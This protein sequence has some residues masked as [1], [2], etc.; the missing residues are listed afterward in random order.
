MKQ[1]TLDI[2]NLDD[3]PMT[4]FDYEQNNRNDKFK[5]LIQLILEYD[6]VVFASPVYW[7]AMSAQMKVFFDRF[8]DLLT[9]SKELG[10]LLRGKSCSVIAT[11]TDVELPNCFFRPFEL[12]AKYL[13]MSFEGYGYLSVK[14]GF[15]V[16]RAVVEVERFLQA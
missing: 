3:Y 5:E 10:R 14:N 11:G 16:K 7:Y 4:F 8:S 9:S 12:T 15:D 1:A 6:H 13:S 2:I